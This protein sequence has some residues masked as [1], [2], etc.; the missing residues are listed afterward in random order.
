[1]K[2]IAE[3]G[4]DKFVAIIDTRE[5]EP[6]DLAPLRTERGTLPTGDYSLKG[7]E[8]V[9]A[10]ERK[11]LSDL[12]G[13]CGGERERFEKEIQRMLAYPCRVLVV[14][15]HL[16]DIEQAVADAKGVYSY[17]YLAPVDGEIKPLYAK[18]K[19]RP[20]SVTGSLLAWQTMGVPVIYS[21]THAQAGIDVARLMF[22]A[23]RRRWR[24]ARALVEGTLTLIE[25]EAT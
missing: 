10:I 4:H 5:Q 24:E 8:H 17:R 6:L 21:G 11:S 19:V 1:M 16:N 25:Q 13:C 15:A 2:M 20:Q 14:E 22:I 23:A 3:P 12:L 18:S 7:L 9:I